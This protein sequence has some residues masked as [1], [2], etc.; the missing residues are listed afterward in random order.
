MGNTIT[1][2]ITTSYV[3]PNGAPY[4]LRA[5]YDFATKQATVTDPLNPTVK[6]IFHNV[7]ASR[8]AILKTFAD[9]LEDCLG[10]NMLWAGYKTITLENEHEK[11]QGN[12]I[13]E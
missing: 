11:L 3:H 1:Q 5:D 12:L 2:P 7:A 4:K 10:W 13:K 6:A 8:F 9:A